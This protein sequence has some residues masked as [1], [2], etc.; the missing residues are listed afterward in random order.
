MNVNTTAAPFL[1]Q[2]PLILASSSPRRRELLRGEG[3]AFR[4]ETL[5][6]DELS[7]SVPLPGHEIAVQNAR[8][9]A[10]PVAQQYPDHLVLGAD[11]VVLCDG[12]LFGKPASEEEAFAMLQALS[13][14]EHS[15]VTGVAL[16]C[17]KAGVE[18]YFPVETRVTFKTLTPETIRTYMQLVPV[19]D[20]AGAYAI[21][22]HGEM[23]LEKMEGSLSNV[24]GLPCEEV[25]ARLARFRQGVLS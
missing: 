4:I 13:G 14:K 20:K 22:D 19:M 11:T 9:K 21:Q 17:V 5:P 25:R 16:Y 12:K 23:I 7:G 24:I 6:C 3:F 2:Y 15:V 18:E 1:L 10:S 8:L